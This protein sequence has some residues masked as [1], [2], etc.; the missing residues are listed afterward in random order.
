MRKEEARQASDK[1]V[2]L[3]FCLY[4]RALKA[5]A[6]ID[7]NVN[8]VQYT[9]VVVL[10]ITPGSLLLYSEEIALSVELSMKD[11]RQRFVLY[12]S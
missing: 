9:S 8:S 11:Q 1:S 12:S 10:K 5:R 3:Y 4:L 2:E 6:L 7:A